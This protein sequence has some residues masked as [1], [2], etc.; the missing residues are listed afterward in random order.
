MKLAVAILIVC[1]MGWALQTDFGKKSPLATLS[2]KAWFGSRVSE[3]EIRRLASTVKPG[4][5]V[6]YTTAE[7]PYCIEAKSWL[8]TYGF[9]YHECNVETT[10]VCAQALQS[11]GGVGVPYV[12]VRGRVLKAGFDKDEFL[13]VL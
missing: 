7:C 11:L 3:E 12:V 4:D 8:A 10:L 5:V 9:P 1:A 2:M 13:S 6:I